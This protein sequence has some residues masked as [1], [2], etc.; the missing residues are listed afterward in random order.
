MHRTG[1]LGFSALVY[2]PVGLALAGESPALAILGYVGVLSLASLP[3]VDL[4]LPL[5]RHRGVTHTLPFAFG[6]GLALWAAGRTLAGPLGL[7]PETLGTFGAFVGVFG[8][9]AHLLADTVTPMG[10]PWLW[11][12]SGRRY[13][14]SL[15]RADDTLANYGLFALGALATAAA[16]ALAVV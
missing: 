11:P 4:R 8:V 5:V 6:V 2:A 13:S 16:A 10:V 15:V 7:P 14:L 9:C 1:H 12:L 3:D